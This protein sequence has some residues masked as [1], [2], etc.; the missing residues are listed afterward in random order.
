[1]AYRANLFG[2]TYYLVANFG[3]VTRQARK[4]CVN[5]CRAIAVFF[6]KMFLYFY[7]N[8]GLVLLTNVALAL[9]VGYYHGYVAGVTVGF[10]SGAI[11]AVIYNKGQDSLRAM[12]AKSS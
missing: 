12:V 1:M 10:I 4:F 9:G 2:L 11:G 5:V 8:A 3:N 7:G 6:A